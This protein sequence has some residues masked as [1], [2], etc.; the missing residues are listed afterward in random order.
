MGKR[1]P[2]ERP[3]R[4]VIVVPLPAKETLVMVELDA[5]KYPRVDAQVGS[6]SLSTRRKAR[7]DG[8]AESGCGGVYSYQS[9]T[10][11]SR[12]N[13]LRIRLRIVTHYLRLRGGKRF[14]GGGAAGSAG[15]AFERLLS[16]TAQTFTD[17]IPMR[18]PRSRS[19]LTFHL[20]ECRRPRRIAFSFV[21]SSEAEP[22][23]HSGTGLGNPMQSACLVRPVNARRSVVRQGVRTA[24]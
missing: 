17:A 2:R 13:K 14:G 4:L 21:A 15:G 20:C 3:Q 11:H 24:R 19:W 6:S 1:Q 23:L 16:A 18:M 5:G 10:M 22:S 12:S 7:G 9:A 8:A